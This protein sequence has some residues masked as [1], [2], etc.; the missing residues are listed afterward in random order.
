MG[1]NITVYKLNHQ[2][3]QILQYSGVELERTP[4][5]V[6]LEA[7]FARNDYPTPYHTFKKGDRMLEWFFSDRWYNIFALH[8]R[9]SNSLEGWYCNITRPARLETDAIYAEDLA[10]DVMI[11]PDGR[12]LVLDEDEFAILDL[13]DLTRQQAQAA[14]AELL[15]LVETRWGPFTAIQP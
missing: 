4:T 1:Q 7:Y 13:D 8:H 10:L 11:Y 15:H 14:L 9:D 2:G 5:S 3:Q 6:L 12:V